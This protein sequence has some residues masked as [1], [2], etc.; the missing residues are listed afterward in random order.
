MTDHLELPPGEAP[1]PRRFAPANVLRWL[2]AATFLAGGAAYLVEGWTDAGAFSRQVTWAVGTL[3]MTVL[4]IVAVRR[5]RDP[6]G[7]RVFLGLAAATIPAHFAQLGAAFYGVQVEGVGTWATAVGA[8]AVLPFLLPPL[9]LGVSALV[10]RRGGTLSAAIFVL[11]LPLLVPTRDP[12]WIAALAGVQVGAW[13]GL[14]AALFR[15]EPLFDSVEGVAA[16]LMLLAPAVIA[17]V[18][19]AFYPMT[20]VWVAAALACPSV[21]LLLWPGVRGLES[22][23]WGAVQIAGV[24][25]LAA[26]ACVCVPPALPLALCLATVLLLGSEVVAGRPAVLAWCAAGFLAAGAAASY[27]EPGLASALAVVPAGSLHVLAAFR[28]RNARLLVVTTLATIAAAV[29]HLAGLVRLPRHDLWIPAVALGV[30]LLTLA[31]LAESRKAQLERVFSRLHR[32]FASETDAK[33]AE[34]SR[35]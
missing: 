27:L 28:R 35:S 31:S 26:A 8:A 10:R 4:G 19:N 30:L 5:L 24:L 33:G 29:L 13:L 12:L 21:V 32:H 15:R 2:G 7:A 20:E 23:A 6:I 34:G 22:R 25:G 3:V 16:R 17:L 11:S 14:E 1:A 18:R 9:S